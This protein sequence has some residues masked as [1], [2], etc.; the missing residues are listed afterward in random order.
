MQCKGG[1]EQIFEFFKSLQNLDRL[2]RIEQIKLVN[3]QDFT[4]QASMQTKA[5]VY[6]RAEAE[7]G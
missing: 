4:G 3:D 7:Q 5:V 1:V 6:Y 2:V